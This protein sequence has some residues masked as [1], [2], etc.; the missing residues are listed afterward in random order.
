[1]ASEGITTIRDCLKRRSLPRLEAALLLAHVLGR[2]REWLI[3]H[4]DE[5]LAPERYD[6]YLTLET[7]RQHGE[8]IAYL[9]GYREFMSLPFVVGPTVLIPRPETEL[10]VEIAR[11]HLPPDATPRMLELGTGSGIIA[12][13]LAKARPNAQVVAT[14]ISE[15]ALGVARLNA[16]RLNVT[17]DFMVGEWFEALNNERRFDL[18]VSNPPYIHPQDSHLQEGDLRF[19]P[20]QALTDGV[21][22]LAAYDAIIG[23]A[24]GRLKPGG[25]LWLEHGFDQAEA[26]TL[27]LGQAGFMQ[28]KTFYDVA[29]Q[30]RVSG[31]SYN[32]DD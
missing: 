16:Q 30:P 4:D 21:N 26:V 10:L 25:W 20:R 5:P 18:I 29:G 3:A 27:R 14:D 8:P 6:A 31:G 24:Q 17:I 32:G 22:G 1:M 13:C 7:R 28:I 2:T 19:E 12:V 15:A 11:Q 23:G 9:L